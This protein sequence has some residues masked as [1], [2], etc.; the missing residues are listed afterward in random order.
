[1]T[2]LAAVVT[3][4]AAFAATNVDDLFVLMLLFGQAQC[5][6]DRRRIAAGQY[7]GVALLTAASLAGA[8]GLGQIPARYVRLLGLVPIA[9]GVRAW[10]KRSDRE[11][12]AVSAL[13]V[14][15]VAALTVANSGDNI[16]VYLPLFS[17]MD[18][19]ERAVILPVFALLCGLWCAVSRRLA[20]L[21]AVAQT[22]SRHKSWL[23]P[24]VLMVLGL[25]VLIG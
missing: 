6:A 20:A 7:V 10:L 18:G 16:G 8:W 14:P 9:L 17:Q 21:P 24:L 5:R 13:S 11:E 25:S 22:I 23:V 4:A 1:M 15:A 2:V 3:A 19:G 12:T